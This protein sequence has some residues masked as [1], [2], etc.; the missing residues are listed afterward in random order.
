MDTGGRAGRGN[1]VGE[2]GLFLQFGLGS[3]L[4]LGLGLEEVLEEG[5]VSLT[6]EESS[7][8]VAMAIEDPATRRL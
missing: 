3:G 7:R 2:G 1:T 6:H 8:I 5:L 4:G